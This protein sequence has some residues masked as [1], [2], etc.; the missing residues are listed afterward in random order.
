M[1][2]LFAASFDEGATETV[3]VGTDSPSMPVHLIDEALQRLQTHDIVIGPS[4]DG[5]YYLLG[6]SA[7]VPELFHGIDWGSGNVLT[8]TLVAAA[9]HSVSLLPVWYD[10]D[11]PEE[12]AFL[13]AHLHALRQAGEEVGQHSLAALEGL[14][15]PPPS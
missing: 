8:Q 4:T 5:G 3:L 9:A 15:L 11:L 12:A 2:A 1:Q 7:P 14:T 10:V 13:R 6:L